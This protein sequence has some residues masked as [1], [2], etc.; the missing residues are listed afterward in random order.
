MSRNI[1]ALQMNGAVIRP[2][3]YTILETSTVVGR[4]CRQRRK[5]KLSRMVTNHLL[6]SGCEAAVCLP[7]CGAPTPLV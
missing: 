2:W 1:L 4:A 7:P 5:K 6:Q 3:A